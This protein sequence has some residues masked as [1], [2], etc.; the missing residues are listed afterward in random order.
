MLGEPGPQVTGSG[1]DQGPGL[2][3]GPGTFPRGTAPGDHQGPDRLD[4]TVPAPGC[5][6]GPAGLRGPG[7]ADRIQGTGLALTAPVLPA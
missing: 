2:V 6:A 7:R 5:T 3:D 4:G 1:Q